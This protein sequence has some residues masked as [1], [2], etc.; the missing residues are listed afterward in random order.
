M[1]AVIVPPRAGVLSAV[2][3]LCSPR[4]RELVR[5]W[6]DPSNRE[7]LDAALAALGDEARAAVAG[8][9]AREGGSAESA[10][11]VEY[12]LDCRYTGQSHELTV[13]SVDAFHT[14]HQRRNGYARRQA[15]VEVVALRARARR[16][17]PLEPGDLPP[18]TRDR[19]AGPAVAIEADCTVWIP[20]GWMAE[21]GP[22][23]AWILTSGEPS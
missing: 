23:G 2:G 21:P 15:P 5:T 13:P 4:Q 12:A 9:A 17:A 20:D 19:R 8:I 3:L 11:D 18:V 10:I 14:E 7:G 16:P 6:P 22:L 1:A